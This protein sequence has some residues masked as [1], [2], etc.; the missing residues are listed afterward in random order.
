MAVTTA[1]QPR[2]QV[3]EHHAGRQRMEQ[4]L[5]LHLRIPPAMVTQAPCMTEGLN[6]TPELGLHNAFT[7]FLLATNVFGF[8]RLN[9][10]DIIDDACI[11]LRPHQI[12][13]VNL[14]VEPV[15]N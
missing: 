4:P 7:E 8:G 12:T 11:A 9:D 2:E 13:L 10:A 6:F 3:V 14:V 1:D 5:A 15:A